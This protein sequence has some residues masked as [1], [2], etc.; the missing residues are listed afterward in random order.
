MARASI[1]ILAALLLAAHADAADQRLVDF[2]VQALGDV[3]PGKVWGCGWSVGKRFDVVLIMVGS[4]PRMQIWG[5]DKDV[6]VMPRLQASNRDTALALFPIV[7]KARI[8]GTEYDLAKGRVFIARSDDG[9][10]SVKQIAALDAKLD[11][12][13]TDAKALGDALQKVPEA[14]AA[15]KQW[16]K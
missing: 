6:T 15:L 1:L 12:L 10:K 16:A 3:Y 11:Q 2:N 7:G 4:D 14:A 9:L 13:G 8:G 5:G